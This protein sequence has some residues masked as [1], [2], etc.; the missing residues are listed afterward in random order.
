MNRQLLTLALV[1]VGL[2]AA[3]KPSKPDGVLSESK[4]EQVLYDFHV[5]KAL[6]T[7][8]DSANIKSRAY[9]LASLEA[10]G[11]T[12]EEFDSSMVWYTQHAE[13]LQKIYKNIDERMSN[14]LAAMGA[15]TN[16]V[17]RYSNLTAKGDTANI[18]NARHFYMLSGNGFNNR[19]TFDIKAD[20]TFRPG[21]TFLFNFRAQFLQQEGQRHG[22]ATLAVQYDN[23][24]VG[25]TTRHFYG[26]GDNSY[27]LPTQP[28]PIKRVYGYVYMISEWSDKPHRL[29]IFQPSLV[30]QRAAQQAPEPPKAPQPAPGDSAKSPAPAPPDSSKKSTTQD[31]P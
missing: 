20:T 16:D 17:N 27:V 9:I 11:V 8:S 1:V 15:A 6:G 21:D 19:F 29:F 28:R 26:S 12:E 31:T 7:A 2:L 5:A 13:F 24:S 10:N 22:I 25:Q 18:W 30:R 4:M 3:C 14:E 23:D